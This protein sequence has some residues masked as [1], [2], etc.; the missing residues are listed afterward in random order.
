MDDDENADGGP[1]TL[2]EPKTPMQLA[3]LKDSIKGNFLFLQIPDEKRD[4]LLDAF[5]QRNVRLGT[6]PTHSLLLMSTL[7][8]IGGDA[9]I[10]EG[11]TGHEFYVVESG[12]YRV[13][14]LRNGAPVE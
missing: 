6:V 1:D 4:M 11:E 13:T 7:L 12:E 9:I 8:V 5:V 14:Q 2:A 10:T 3:K